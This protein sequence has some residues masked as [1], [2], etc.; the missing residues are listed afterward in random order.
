MGFLK[1]YK[2][3]IEAAIEEYK[4]TDQP[5]QLYEP[6]NYILHLGGKRLRPVI[7][8]MAYNLFK[9]DLKPAVKA[10]LGIEYF[11]NFSLMHDDIMDRAALRRGKETVHTK[12]D[13][14]IAILSGDA[15][16]VKA[17]QM[18]EDLNPALFKP[19]FQLF[20]HT[21]LKVC[22]G[23]QYDMN[24]EEQN[25]VSY[26][27]YIHMITGKTAEL[28]ACALKMGALVAEA[29]EEDAE[30]LYE[31][32][33]HLGIAFQL[34][35]DYLD[36][37]GDY[38]VV[39]KKHAGDICENKKTIL[40]I[41]AKQQGN[42]KQRAELDFWFDSKEEKTEKI[43]TVVKLFKD[44]DVDKLCLELINDYTEQALNCLEKITAS[45]EK[46]QDFYELMDYLLIRES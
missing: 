45:E 32:G 39:G 25:D 36:V 29:D 30:N 35:D 41:L 46:K 37:F 4:F 18:L 38:E 2:N 17:F 23:Q 7:L 22:E 14:N 27:E 40:Y 33:L 31:F 12:Y 13:E 9:D 19:C 21:A 15:L 34:M 3:I 11:H 28:C 16:L 6:M 10:A 8:L 43:H 42:E 5:A 24:F 44:L 1:K 20:S 26:G